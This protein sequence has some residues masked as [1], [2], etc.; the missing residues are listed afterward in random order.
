MISVQGSQING[1]C[2]STRLFHGP[3]DAPIDCF[4][5]TFP[6]LA[7]GWPAPLGDDR[8]VPFVENA[9]PGDVRP[10][11]ARELGTRIGP[12][13]PVTPDVAVASLADPQPDLPP[14]EC[15]LGVRPSQTASSRARRNWWP[16]TTEAS[17]AVV[18]NGP[19]PGMVVSRLSAA[20]FLMFT[21]TTEAG[22]APR[23]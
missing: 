22:R 16:S 15:S 20:F 6:S 13:A 12:R 11:H 2:R 7:F 23:S 18:A 3:L 14:V 10:C 1:L 9:R 8:V 17:S 5:I 4:V 19:I 21:R